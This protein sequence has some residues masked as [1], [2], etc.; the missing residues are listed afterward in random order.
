MQKKILVIYNYFSTNKG[1]YSNRY[2]ELSKIWID[3]GYSVEFITSPYFKSDISCKKIFEIQNI[4]GIK[5]NV[6]NFPDGGN[7]SLAKRLLNSFMFTSIATLI[8]LFKPYDLLICSSGPFTIGIPNLLNILF[9]RKGVK[10]FEIRDI[11]PQTGI[12]YK[13]I[14]NKI[15]I[16]LAYFFEK[17]QYKYSNFI[18]TL[19]DGQENYIKE[20]F[21]RFSHKIRTI[22]QISNKELFNINLPDATLDKYKNKYGL[23]FTY[24]GGLGPIHNVSYWIQLFSKLNKI[25]KSKFSLII[26]GDGPDK[27]KLE[28]LSLNLGLKNV[29]FIGQIPKREIPFWLK[30]SYA[31]LFSTTDLPVQQTCAPNKVFDSFS[32]GTP[33]IQTSTGW[34]KSFIGKTDCGISVDLNNIDDSAELVSQYI[35][36]NDKRKLHHENSLKNAD[37][38]D[39]KLLAQKYLNLI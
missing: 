28:S 4:E 19:S 15:I 9:K 20:R 21:P 10:V 24:I 25:N 30:L 2:Y 6:I 8:S 37:R 13:V 16:K 1:S 26:L 11:W 23:V 18:V 29:N 39:K 33:L 27:E 22:P 17:L 38:F 14:T 35:N 5:L 32:S 34:I 3:K 7:K 36:N 12:E 31:T